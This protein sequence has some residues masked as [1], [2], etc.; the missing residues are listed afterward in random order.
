MKVCFLSIFAAFCLL[1]SLNAL[2]A[3]AQFEDL[4]GLN[5]QI[6]SGLNKMGFTTLRGYVPDGKCQGFFNQVGVTY[7][8]GTGSAALDKILADAAKADF[9][10]YLNTP[11]E[12]CPENVDATDTPVAQHRKTFTATT[13][14]KKYLSFFFSVFEE[15][16][17]A[18]HP[19]SASSAVVYDL[20]SAKPIELG[21]LFDDPKKAM[22]ELWAYVAKGWCSQD[23]DTLPSYYNLGDDD[24]ACGSKTPPL[25]STFNADPVPFTALGAVTLT[26]KGLTIQIDALD[27]WAY[28]DGPGTFE[29]PKD[30]LVSI[31]AKKEVWE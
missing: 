20:Q 28:S 14:G 9:D 12:S 10:K 22:P 25:P 7:P 30:Y 2:P 11:M 27:A 8:F 13:A 24:S 16:P 4:Y 1:V 29:V 6:E 15:I 19:S 26:P 23:K 3:S 21:A 31:G 5:P 17:F 18:A